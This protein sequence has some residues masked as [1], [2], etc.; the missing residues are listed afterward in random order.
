MNNDS[1]VPFREEDKKVGRDYLPRTA[2][3]R[4]LLLTS[5]YNRDQT[6]AGRKMTSLDELTRGNTGPN[7]SDAKRRL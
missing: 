3:G 7:P 1:V 6:R 2:T 5:A 4:N